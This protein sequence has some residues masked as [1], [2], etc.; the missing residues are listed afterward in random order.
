MPKR[1]KSAQEPTTTPPKCSSPSK[2]RSC[3]PSRPSD[4]VSSCSTTGEQARTR[5]IPTAR[6][7]STNTTNRQTSKSPSAAEALTFNISGLLAE[8]AGSV[9]DYEIFGPALNL[10]PEVRQS[11]GL[12]GSLR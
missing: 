12:D 10:G 6:E 7:T 8:P 5:P 4:T 1:G 11:E 9:R 2:A 3:A